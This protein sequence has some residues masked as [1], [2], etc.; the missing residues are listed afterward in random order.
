MMNFIQLESKAINERITEGT[1][2][3]TSD[4]C[5]FSC[6]QPSLD[7]R[8]AELVNLNFNIFNILNRSKTIVI[9]RQF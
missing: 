8:R 2:L 4:E 6:Q 3:N 9:L 7:A 5:C 1:Q